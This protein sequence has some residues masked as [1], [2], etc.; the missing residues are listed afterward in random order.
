MIKVK[1]F[2]VGMT[3]FQKKNLFQNFTKYLEDREMNKEGVGLGLKISKNIA[4]AL[5]GDISVESEV[6]RGSCFT[7]SLPLN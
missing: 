6:G 3:D 2:G 7:L 5:G 4:N 1:D